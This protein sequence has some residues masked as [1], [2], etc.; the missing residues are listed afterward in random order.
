M[1]TNYYYLVST[2]PF[3]Q[4]GAPPPRSSAAF[5]ERCREH[6]PAERAAALAAVA[7]LPRA[8]ACCPSEARWNARETALRNLLVRRRCGPNDDPTRHLR[9]EAEFYGDLE[10]EVDEALGAAHPL[11]VEQAL[12]RVRWDFLDDLASGH[13]FDFDVLLLYRLRLLLLEQGAAVE[14]ARGREALAGRV[15]EKL[16]AVN[17]AELLNA[18]QEPR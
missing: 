11:A 10:L 13:Q 16:A 8:T 7:L 5:L 15:R 2:L 14:A 4:C 6:L 18:S 9:P 17:V 3:A 12:D 1:V